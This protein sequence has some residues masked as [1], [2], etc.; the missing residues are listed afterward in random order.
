MAD[1]LILYV[2]GGREAGGFEGW[3]RE[4][5]PVNILHIDYEQ[6]EW[7]DLVLEP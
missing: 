5:P 1:A 7:K 2:Q 6:R 4:D 3:G